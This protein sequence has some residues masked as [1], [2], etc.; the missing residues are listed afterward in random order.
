MNE[1][2]TENSCF[3]LRLIYVHRLYLEPFLEI[4]WQ[5]K[6]VL[7]FGTI[8]FKLK[9]IVLKWKKSNSI[10]SEEKEIDLGV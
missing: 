4:M 5:K 10:A 3:V 2:T 9:I 7:F 8:L 6:N 1:M